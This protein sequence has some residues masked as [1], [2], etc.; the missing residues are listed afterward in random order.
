MRLIATSD[1]R[2]G[3]PGNPQWSPDGN[4]IAFVR[5]AHQHDQSLWVSPSTGGDSRRLGSLCGDRATWAP[6]G[7]V[8]AVGIFRR[9]GDDNN[10]DLATISATD[11]HLIRNLA[12]NASDGVFSPD[13][14]LYV[15]ARGRELRLISFAANRVSLNAERLLVRE[16]RRVSTPAW[17]S[18]TQILYLMPGSPSELRR[19]SATQGADAETIPIDVQ[20]KK[21]TAS[22]NGRMLLAQ[23][24]TTDHSLWRLDLTSPQPHFEELRRI[25]P[26][27]DQLSISPDASRLAYRSSRGGIWASNLDGSDERRVTDTTG[28]RPVWSPNDKTIGFTAIAGETTAGPRSF[29]F[30]VPS[31]GGR[32]QRVAPSVED[33]AA[34]SWS[35]NGEWLYF[36]RGEIEK[37]QI[38]K[39]RI[40]DGHATQVTR[41]GGFCG[42]ESADGRFFYYL[43]NPGPKIHRVPV[44][45]GEEVL[46]SDANV[47]WWWTFAVGSN[48]LYFI[49]QHARETSDRTLWRMDLISRALEAVGHVPFDPRWMKL[50]R[51]EL[52]L[53]A[54][55]SSEPKQ[56]IVQIGG[57]LGGSEPPPPSTRL[58]R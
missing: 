40:S 3:V 28:F 36:A 15:Y 26:F 24:E 51:D 21:I 25:R 34:L 17:I 42:Q 5:E 2:T 35:R 47:E 52:S 37:I 11:G 10:C 32:A 6:S 50:S 8:L 41:Q 9:P 14:Q 56:S 18:D 30:V 27:D 1:D 23:I 54:E 19:I 7:Q 39:L 44:E 22:H 16:P 53:Y 31:T 45:G 43:T 13:G 49:S 38:W 48:R 12:R 55:N 29:L 57:A 58:R 46:L 33:G 20:L 4:W